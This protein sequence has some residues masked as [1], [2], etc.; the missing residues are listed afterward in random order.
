M[1]V[2]TGSAL[3]VIN[4]QNDLCNNSILKIEKSLDIIPK[5]NRIKKYFNTIV[6]C[7]NWHPVNHESFLEY[8]GIWNVNCVKH[9]EGAELHN[10]LYINDKH[11]YILHKEIIEKFDSYSSF[12]NSKESNNKTN[13]DKILEEN[14]IQD[15][16]ICGIGGEYSIYATALD[17][18]KFRYKVFLI[19]DAIINIQEEKAKQCYDY[20]DKLEIKF[21]CCGDIEKRKHG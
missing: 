2:S 12:Y 3:L 8:G 4:V 11:D 16:Y 6:F 5:I 21:L 7:K 14:E 9:T 1:K 15:V 10:G 13:L 18:I 20:L 19:M 17:A